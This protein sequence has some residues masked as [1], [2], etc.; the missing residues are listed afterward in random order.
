MQQLRIRTVLIV[1]LLVIIALSC[2]PKPAAVLPP[3]QMIQPVAATLPEIQE[4]ED[5]EIVFTNFFPKDSTGS[6]HRTGSGKSTKDFK[7]NKQGWCTYD[8]F[9]VVGTATYECI[10]SNDDGCKKYTSVPEGIA[11]FNYWD[12]FR[13]E[14]G[15]VYYD[16]V[17]L[18]SCG[19]CHVFNEFDYGLQRFDIM[20]PSEEYRFGKIKAKMLKED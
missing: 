8:G 12:T 17:V 10:R 14:Y 15:G 5:V 11:L 13:F 6:T 4:T 7:L 1:L 18:D 16:A 19:A 2:A 20:I 3:K 9:V